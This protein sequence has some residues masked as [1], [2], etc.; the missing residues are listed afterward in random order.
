MISN[1]NAQNSEKPAKKPGNLDRKHI[2]AI[3]TAEGIRVGVIAKALDVR[4]ET[5]SRWRQEPAFVA[6]VAH[7][8][9]EI[10]QGAAD[11]M[12]SLTNKAVQ[13]VES[14]LDA[15]DAAPEDKLRAAKL[16][17][18]QTKP[19]GDGMDHPDLHGRYR[20]Q[21]VGDGEQEGYRLI[22]TFE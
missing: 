21:F 8:R 13:T 12:R 17:L 4:P 2:A 18:E 20:V 10:L 1:E 11:R 6:L 16:I 5:V 14:I 15:A 19:L 9:R 3:R 22:D 7:Y